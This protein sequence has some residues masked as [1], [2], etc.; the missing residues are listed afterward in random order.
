MAASKRFGKPTG[1]VMR[2]LLKLSY[3]KADPWRPVSHPIS[4]ML[5]NDSIA[6]D[7]SGTIMSQFVKKYIDEMG[8]ELGR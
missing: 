2:H 5:L 7:T 1:V 8:K 6:H 3:V 4:M